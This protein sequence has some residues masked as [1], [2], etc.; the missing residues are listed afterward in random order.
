MPTTDVTAGTADALPEMLTV[1]E[2]AHRLRIGRTLAYQLA[3]RF[4]DGEAGGIPAIRLGGTL[5]VPRAPLDDLM[6]LGRVVTPDDVAATVAVALDDYLSD[7]EP[8][9]LNQARPARDRR[10]TSN[11]AAQLSLLEAD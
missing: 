9:A 2:A 1:S 6:R 7:A 3:A 10:V 4:L 5:R 8:T 11:R